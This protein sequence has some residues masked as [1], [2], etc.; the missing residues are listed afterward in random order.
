MGKQN[1]WKI[2]L[3]IATEKGQNDADT[4]W[5]HVLQWLTYWSRQYFLGAQ[6]YGPILELLDSITEP[7]SF[8]SSSRLV[9]V[10]QESEVSI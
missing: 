2:A 6:E 9:N 1:E 10:K 3:R 4:R 7:N 5:K 8:L